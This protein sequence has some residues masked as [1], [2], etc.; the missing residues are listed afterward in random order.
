MIARVCVCLCV[1]TKKIARNGNNAL[2]FIS[3]TRS[4]FSYKHSIHGISVQFGLFVLIIRFGELDIELSLTN[5]QHA[6][7][8]IRTQAN[9]HFDYPKKGG[10]T[11]WLREETAF[12]ECFMDFKLIPKPD[13]FDLSKQIDEICFN[14]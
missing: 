3:V 10:N 11:N 8:S 13:G 6:R 14:T 5:F 2:R 4:I 12:S 1:P 7:N 9:I